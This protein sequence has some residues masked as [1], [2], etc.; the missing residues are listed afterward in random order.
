METVYAVWIW[1]ERVNSWGEYSVH[2]SMASAQKSLK[3]AES[4]GYKAKVEICEVVSE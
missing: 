2:G 3:V 1:D 4:H